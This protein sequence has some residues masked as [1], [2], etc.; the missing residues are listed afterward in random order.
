VRGGV[1]VIVDGRRVIQGAE[2]VEVVLAEAL[3]EAR[4]RISSISG[5]RPSTLD[6]FISVTSKK[7]DWLPFWR[8][9]S[10]SSTRRPESWAMRDANDAAST[11]VPEPPRGL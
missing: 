7:N 1:G 5:L 4:T 11:L 8:S 10:T 6:R 3:V 2:D 9:R